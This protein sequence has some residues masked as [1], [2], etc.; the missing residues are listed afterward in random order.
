MCTI[1]TFWCSN[2]IGSN[3]LSFDCQFFKFSSE[4]I[5]LKSQFFFSGVDTYN[6]SKLRNICGLKVNN[7]LPLDCLF[8][9]ALTMVCYSKTCRIR[10]SWRKIFCLLVCL[11]FE[12][13]FKIQL[14]INTGRIRF[15][16]FDQNVILLN[17]IIK[18]DSPFSVSS[19][20]K[21]NFWKGLLLCHKA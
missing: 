14:L 8:L 17:G 18:D 20:K 13:Q 12:F 21:D 1:K 10:R 19:L 4:E 11:A 7:I 15:V 6:N 16:L 5:Q 2:L 9:I 3:S